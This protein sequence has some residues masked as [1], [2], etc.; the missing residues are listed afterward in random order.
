[1]ERRLAALGLALALLALSAAARAEA[2]WSYELWNE[3]MSP[4]CP[5]RTLSDC[6]SGEAERLRAW[7]VSQEEAGRD[8]DE[9]RRELFE[10]FGDG[11]RQAPA[12]TGVGLAAYA[13]PI[14]AFLAGGSLVGL[15]LRRQGRRRAGG[16]RPA[17]SVVDPELERALDQ[18]IGGGRD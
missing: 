10:R 4:F 7:I 3:L 2:G 14:A 6:P 15:F 11:I 1:V 18:E 8:V 17:V 5:G 13:I 9:V 12:P 16:S